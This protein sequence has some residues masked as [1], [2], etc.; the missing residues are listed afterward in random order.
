MGKE[1]FIERDPVISS[2]E[3]WAVSDMDGVV[4]HVADHDAAV[5]VCHI[6]NSHDRLLA[7]LKDILSCVIGPDSGKTIDTIQRIANAA[8]RGQITK[9]KKELRGE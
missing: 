3:R 4:V 9:P 7:A 6:L 5:L 2:R 8:L 1:Y